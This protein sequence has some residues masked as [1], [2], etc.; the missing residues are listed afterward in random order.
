MNGD[1]SSELGRRDED[2]LEG[3]TSNADCMTEL[4]H[5]YY[6]VT[7]GQQYFHIVNWDFEESKTVDV[8]IFDLGAKYF[9]NIM[10]LSIAAL[11][12]YALSM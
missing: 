7:Y 11:S 8:K 12:V 5:N 1:P 6:Y 3:Y 9:D 10:G 4:C 2:E